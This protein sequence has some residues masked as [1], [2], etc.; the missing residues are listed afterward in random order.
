[1]SY[2]HYRVNDFV[3]DASFR[4]WVLSPNEELE[5]FW[6]SWLLQHPL[7]AGTIQEA[8]LLVSLTD[9]KKVQHTKEDFDTTRQQIKA[10]LFSKSTP[11]KESK[12]QPSNKI[13]SYLPPLGIA[14]A[15]SIL[16]LFG[17]YFFS[18]LSPEVQ[19]YQTAFG[20]IREVELPDGS[21]AILNANSSLKVSSQW[22]KKREVWLVGEAFFEVEKIRKKSHSGFTYSK[23]TVHAGEV[24]IEVLG[25]RF[26]VLNRSE[27]TEVVLQ[28]GAVSL[29]GKE[30]HKSAITM[31]EGDAFAYSSCR[32]TFQKKQIDTEKVTAWKKGVHMFDASSLRSIAQLLKDNYGLNVNIEDKRLEERRFSAQVPYGEVD[33]LLSLLEESLL[34]DIRQEEDN[35]QIRERK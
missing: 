9:Y 20:E 2:E 28:E 7:M 8:R 29:K 11:S 10:V 17:F 3:S 19:E 23:F 34:L 33:M 24:D 16:S 12:R 15:I 35:I 30:K 13:R 27:Q 21:L 31:Q 1:M 5:A 6:E 14:A 18:T 4:A 26:N 25:T 32:H 22:Q